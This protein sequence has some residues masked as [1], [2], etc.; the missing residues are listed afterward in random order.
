V[1]QAAAYRIQ[2]LVHA[3]LAAAGGGAIVGY[4]IGCTTAVM[5]SFM[6]ID[7][8]CAGG[9]WSESVRQDGA[10]IRTAD[11]ARLGVE[12]EIAAVLGRTLPA[13]DA[14]FGRDRIAGAVAALHA[15][16][17]LVDDRYTD[18][19][20]LDVHT[21][22]ADDFFGAG[23][24][25]GPA[26]TEWR[27]LDLAGAAGILAVNGSVAGRG[28]AADVLGHPLE[29]LTWLA[30]LEAGRGR[31]LAAGSLVLLGSL[32]EPQWPAPGDT[33]TWEV[34]GL[35]SVSARFL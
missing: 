25:L 20:G 23:A 32:V 34:A 11:F 10:A 21:L 17:E 4:M 14:P 29:A 18:W 6:T 12:C 19:R 28:T 13:A 24:V 2:D 27:S 22:T 5:Q 7:H 26:M 31:D 16:F 3:R 8:P 15:A 1:D 30:N 33:M 9:I 35:G